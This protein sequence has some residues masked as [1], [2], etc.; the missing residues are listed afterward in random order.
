MA[1]RTCP[2]CKKETELISIPAFLGS[3]YSRVCRNCSR[4]LWQKYDIEQGIECDKAQIKPT[5]KQQEIARVAREFGA[6]V[7]AEDVK[8]VMMAAREVDNRK[9]KPEKSAV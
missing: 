7:S 1:S 2:V 6:E 5:K 4:M 8:L 9:R 3:S